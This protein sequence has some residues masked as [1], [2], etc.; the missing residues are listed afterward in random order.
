MTAGEH[1]HLRRQSR[2]LLLTGV[3]LLVGD[4]VFMLHWVR[5]GM[6]VGGVIGAT[7]TSLKP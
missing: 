3:L 1:F 5:F 7:S 6:P 2:R 4:V